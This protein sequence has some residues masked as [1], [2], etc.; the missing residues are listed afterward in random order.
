MFCG[1]AELVR[2]KDTM[3]GNMS[4]AGTNTYKKVKVF[5]V[6]QVAQ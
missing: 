4:Q 6:F 5:V 1:L 3:G 2:S